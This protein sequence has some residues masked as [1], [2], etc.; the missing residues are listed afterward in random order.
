MDINYSFIQYVLSQ[1]FELGI[2]IN[3]P[4]IDSNDPYFSSDF[5]NLNKNL[6]FI[7]LLNILQTNCI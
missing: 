3:E 6:E 2:R 5:I 1:S 4:T 7:F